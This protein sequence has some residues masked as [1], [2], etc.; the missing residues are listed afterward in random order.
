MHSHKPRSGRWFL[1]PIFLG[2]I[3]GPAACFVFRRD[4]PKKA[5]NCPYLRAVL[6]AAM[7]VINLFHPVVVTTLFVFFPPKP[8]MP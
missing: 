5:K 6:T 3:G 4:D 1:I 7:L 8:P 2:I